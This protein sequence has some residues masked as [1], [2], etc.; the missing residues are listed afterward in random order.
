ME[1]GRVR[2]NFGKKNVSRIGNVSLL[3]VIILYFHP[4]MNYLFFASEITYVGCTWSYPAHMAHYRSQICITGGCFGHSA[5]RQCAP[6]HPAPHICTQD[7]PICWAACNKKVLD[8]RY[9]IVGLALLK[10]ARTAAFACP[11]QACWWCAK[12]LGPSESLES[13]MSIPMCNCTLAHVF[14]IV[15]C[16]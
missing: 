8:I 1:E 13:S 16:V 4:K 12:K 3:P 11:H 9:R 10:R 5:P 7:L 14:R 2:T 15:H 6:P